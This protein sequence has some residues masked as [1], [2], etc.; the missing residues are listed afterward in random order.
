MICPPLYVPLPHIYGGSCEMKQMARVWALL[1]C[2]MGR[3]D[4]QPMY[5][6]VHVLWLPPSTSRALVCAVLVNSPL[7]RD[8]TFIVVS[9]WALVKMA[10]YL[11]SHVRRRLREGGGGVVL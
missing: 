7:S 9:K 6:M 10:A 5:V 4:T 11:L 8:Y 3:E 1:C 2:Y